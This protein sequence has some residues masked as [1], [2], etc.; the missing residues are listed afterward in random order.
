MSHMNIEKSKLNL[1]KFA[2]TPLAQLNYED[3]LVVKDSIQYFIYEFGTKAYIDFMYSIGT[4]H[5][6][7]DCSNTWTGNPRTKCPSCGSSFLGKKQNDS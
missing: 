2:K 5:L 7:H 1:K 3:L 4:H 6:C